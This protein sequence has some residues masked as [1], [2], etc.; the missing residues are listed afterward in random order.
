LMQLHLA[1]LEAFRQIRRGKRTRLETLGLLWGKRATDR[2]EYRYVVEHVTVDT[3]AKRQKNMVSPSP[4]DAELKD[5]IISSF[6]PELELLGEFHTHPYATTGQVERARGYEFSREDRAALKREMHERDVYY[7]SFRV[8][9]VMAIAELKR[10][11]WQEPKKFNTN[12]A[13]W[14]W[15]LKRHRF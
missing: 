10:S 1:A 15:T 3:F 13:T 2:N 5:E 11:G 8:G 9:L 4:D 7:D 12:N 6:W 14:K